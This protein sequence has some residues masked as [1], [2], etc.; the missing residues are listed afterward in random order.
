MKL[1]YKDR[2]VC[3]PSVEMRVIE[4]ARQRVTLVYIKDTPVNP[5][6]K[7][8]VAAIQDYM[9]QRAPIGSRIMIEIV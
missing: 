4:G 7:E 3:D 9:D 2:Q 6:R 1:G 8:H 5:M